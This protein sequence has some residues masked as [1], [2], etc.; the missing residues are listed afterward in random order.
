MLF[1]VAGGCGLG[2]LK[3]ADDAKHL[4][5]RRRR[6]PVQGREARPDERHQARR[7]RR[8]DAIQQAQAGQFQGGTDLLFNLKNHGVGVGQDQPERPGVVD[9]ADEQLPRED[10]RREPSRFRLRS[11]RT[12]H[13][14]SRR[15]GPRC[16]PLAFPGFIGSLPSGRGARPRDAGDP[17]GV[18]RRSRQRRRRLRRPPGRGTRAARR[19]RRRAS[20]R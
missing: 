19:E 12:R 5:H 9:Q 14:S 20:R 15:G 10:H 18:P 8:L 7:Q 2:T 4:G 6:R 17:Q 13:S 11:A 16:P 3:A 1:Q